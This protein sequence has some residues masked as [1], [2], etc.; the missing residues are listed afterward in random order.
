MNLAADGEDGDVVF[1]AEGFGGI[2]DVKGC[3]VAGMA[4]AIEAEELAG[5]AAGFDD[6]VGGHSRI[7]VFHVPFAGRTFGTLKPSFLVASRFRPESY[8]SGDGLRRA[9]TCEMG[10]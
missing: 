3:L 1:L 5:W 4:H 8:P 9:I 7:G 6:V 10:I 2:G